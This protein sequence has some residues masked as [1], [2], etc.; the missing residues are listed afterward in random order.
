MVQKT[1]LNNGLRI[2][3]EEIPH[4]H[5]VAMGVWLN[6]GSRDEA[7]SENGLSHFLEH[8]AFKGTPRR[9]AL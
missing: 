5:S 3:T 1:V 2:V 6:V 9:T 7:G 8:M 4:F